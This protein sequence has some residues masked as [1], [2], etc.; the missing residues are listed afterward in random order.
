MTSRRRISTASTPKPG[1]TF[2][3]AKYTLNQ[4]QDGSYASFAVW[5]KGVDTL[6]PEVDVVMFFDGSKPEPRQIVARLP[7]GR[8]QA[9]L[10]ER[11]LDTQ[12]FPPRFYVSQFPSDAELD[13]MI[14]TQ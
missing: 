7:W 5:S 1:R 14:R 9:V 13:E 2:F 11:M 6:L 12:M 4:A 8:V 10:G 3:V